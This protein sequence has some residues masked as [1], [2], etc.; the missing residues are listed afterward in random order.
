MVVL[1]ELVAGAASQAEI[2]LDR[3][4]CT[5][6]QLTRRLGPGSTTESDT[7]AVLATKKATWFRRCQMVQAMMV[8]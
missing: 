6:Y 3:V 4:A 1:F 7:D 8:A 5:I 2:C